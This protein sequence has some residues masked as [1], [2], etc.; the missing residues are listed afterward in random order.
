MIAIT[1]LEAAGLKYHGS[2]SFI[3]AIS[4]RRYTSAILQRENGCFERVMFSLEVAK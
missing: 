3:S 1:I 4:G 2:F